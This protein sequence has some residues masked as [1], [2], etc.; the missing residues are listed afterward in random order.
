MVAVL[1]Y[2]FIGLIDCTKM[3][4][5][6][7]TIPASEFINSLRS[8]KLNNIHVYESSLAGT[9]NTQFKF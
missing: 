2:I 5:Y 1:K 3:K 6:E 8:F 9:H 7:K 4:T